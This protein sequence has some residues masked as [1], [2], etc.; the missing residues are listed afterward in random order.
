MSIMGRY[1]EPISES[2]C[3]SDRF[4]GL[5]TAGEPW[6]IIVER[7]FFVDHAISGLVYAIRCVVQLFILLEKRSARQ[8]QGYSVKEVLERSSFVYEQLE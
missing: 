7:Q 3:A 8:C 6:R 2:N 1:S 5:V 4:D